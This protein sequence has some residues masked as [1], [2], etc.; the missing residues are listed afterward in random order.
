MI[1]VVQSDLYAVIGHPVGHSLS[2]AMMNAAFAGL[3]LD[4]HYLAFDTDDC[5]GALRL[6]ADLGVRGLS[7]TIPHKQTACQLAMKLDETAHA[8]GAVNTL[9]RLPDSGDWE[10]IN[11]DWLGA[12]RAL[13]QVTQLS[14]KRALVV[15]AG[16]SARAVVYGL[17]HEGAVVSITNRTPERGEALAETFQCGFVPIP[18]TS[19]PCFDI[20]VQCTSVGLAGTPAS[21]LLPKSVLRSGMVVMDLVYRPRWTPF[22][23]AA[24]DVG[25]IT[26]SGLDMLL[27]QGVAQFEWWLQ[28]PAPLSQMKE[29]LLRAFS[30]ENHDSAH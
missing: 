14:G 6:L 30:R 25:C 16:G 15:G 20:V 4:A 22:L 24:R 10:G 29:A 23:T 26:V 11:T 9:K 12:V 2:P 27:F 7:V 5:A 1:H 8:I 28:R 17:M 13:Q 21:E 19:Q 3:G 18:E